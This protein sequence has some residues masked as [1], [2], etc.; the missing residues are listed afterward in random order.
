[1]CALYC[2]KLDTN[3]SCDTAILNT[4]LELRLGES[5]FDGTHLCPLCA[6]ACY[7]NIPC[8][9]VQEY[10]AF[11][12]P[13]NVSKTQRQHNSWDT[14]YRILKHLPLCLQVQTKQG[15]A[16]EHYL[17]QN[18][19]KRLDILINDPRFA[20][21]RLKT[22]KTHTFQRVYVLL[23]KLRLVGRIAPQFNL[24][25]LLFW[26]QSYLHRRY[27]GWSRFSQPHT[28]SDLY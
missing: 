8:I 7:T 5:L 13:V 16:P 6:S 2:L 22:L 26:V 20:E 19:H 27:C 18:V 1:M 24:H 17:S 3:P 4:L 12:C 9:D 15:C 10:H 21:Q 28:K 25:R 14:L 23:Q 11:M